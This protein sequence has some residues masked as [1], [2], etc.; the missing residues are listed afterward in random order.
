M[1]GVSQVMVVESITAIKE[2]LAAIDAELVQ[3]G[4]GGWANEAKI[5]RNLAWLATAAS[6]Q[7]G[8]R[9]D[10]RPTDQLV[11]R[12]A[13]VEA[14]LEEQLEAFEMLVDHELDDLNLTLSSMQIPSVAVESR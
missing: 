12:L 11:E 8:E 13:D 5:Q 6:S 7:R 10:A 1:A 4:G 9:T 3:T 14:V 2:E